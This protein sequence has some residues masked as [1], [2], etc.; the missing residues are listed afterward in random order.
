MQCKDQDFECKLATSLSLGFNWISN[1]GFKFL[2]N[3]YKR[4]K[5]LLFITYINYTFIGEMTLNETV[6]GETNYCNRLSL[7]Q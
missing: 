6:Q 3:Y 2:V 1:L 4:L 5:L 7:S